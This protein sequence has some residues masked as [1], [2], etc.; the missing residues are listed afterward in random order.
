MKDSIIE[1]IRE[2][3]L[4]RSQ[5]GIQKY[6]TTLDRSDYEIIDW[7]KHMYE[8][9]LDASGYLKAL[10][11]KITYGRY[12]KFMSDTHGFHEQEPLEPVDILIH[13][14]DSTN[15]R[16]INKNKIEWERFWD[17][18]CKYPATHRIYVPGNHDTYVSVYR[19]DIVLPDNTYILCHEK[20]NIDGIKIWGSP[21]VPV[22][23]QWAFMKP[24]D[25]LETLW[26]SIDDDVDILLTHGPPKYILDKVWEKGDKIHHTGDIALYNK[27]VQ[28]KPIIHAFGH[29]HD[30][31]YSLN[32]GI[33]ER[34]GIKYINGS[35]VNDSMFEKGLVNKSIII[36]V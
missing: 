5:I 16:D 7:I 36:K 33:F 12:I 15:H 13:T 30:N 20:L 34:D 31:Q 29:I 21:Y 19:K 17:W 4:R 9:L 18:F 6:G 26:Q 22:Y 14:G 28:I 25:S 10:E 11:K 35:Q 27:V 1:S 2:D 8:E 23:G 3:L 32:H 24:I